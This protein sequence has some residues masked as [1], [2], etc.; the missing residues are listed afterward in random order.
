MPLNAIRSGTRESSVKIT[1]IRLREYTGTLEHPGVFWEERLIRPID[2]YPEH[3][4]EA[5]AAT[6]GTPVNLGDG[7]HRITAAFV[8]VETDE[9]VP[10]LAGP[11]AADVAYIIG[12]QFRSLLIGEDPLATERIWDKMYRSAVHGRKGPT[13][14]AISAID[15]ALWD[16]KGRWAN[17]P[18]YK[19]LGGPIRETLPA[20]A[21]MLGY[22]I[23]PEKAAERAKEAVA[24]GYQAM[25]WFPRG[26]PVDGKA[27]IA[28]NVELMRSLREA[29]GPDVDIMF[30]AWMSWTVPFTLANAEQLAE[31]E[32]RWI[33]EPVMP[34]KI[35]ECAEIRHRSPVPTSTG[36]HEYT[37][38]G[39]KQ[40]LD[41]GAADY[42]QPDTYW[43]GG[44]SELMKIATIASTYDIPVI[45]HG[46]S[47][48]ANVH[49]SAA[50]P[51]L[52]VPLVEFLVKWNAVHQFFW[53][54]PLV[55]INGYVTVPQ[56]PGMG[57]GIDEGKVE[58]SRELTWE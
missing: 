8:E 45:P 13:M 57:M 27:G 36:E 50:L 9:G 6:T 4:A 28:R 47:V 19:L 58:S 18:V 46:H 48:P 39:L 11:V 55:P 5:A 54:D 31:F 20:Y 23:E 49:L 22:S 26:G 16:L 3:N 10:G 37:R 30:D 24:Q 35:A 14:M 7:R 52:S 12:T 21:S 32:P 56:G 44:I 33:E 29:V 1:A 41:A 40:L 51:T 43:A 53:K 42:L 17:A 15:C 25:K 38:W 2:V 34:D